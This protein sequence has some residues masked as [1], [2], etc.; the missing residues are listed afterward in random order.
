MAAR[1][2]RRQVLGQLPANADEVAE[3]VGEGAQ[4]RWL[5]AIDLEPGGMKEPGPGRRA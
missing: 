4:M 5:S 3:A 1:K 2:L